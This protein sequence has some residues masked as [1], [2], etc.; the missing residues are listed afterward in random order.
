MLTLR[1][2]ASHFGS[3]SCTICLLWNWQTPSRYES[4]VMWVNTQVFYTIFFR[5]CL[6]M[7]YNYIKSWLLYYLGTGVTWNFPC[8]NFFCYKVNGLD[9]HSR[10]NSKSW[11][12]LTAS[13]IFLRWSFLLGARTESFISLSAMFFASLSHERPVYFWLNW[14]GFRYGE[15]CPTIMQSFFTLG[16]GD[17]LS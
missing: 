8:F 6:E 4:H 15:L 12:E 1:W 5:T 2:R 7:V 9:C 11:W 16:L 10:Y 17:S 13:K 3:T 14:H